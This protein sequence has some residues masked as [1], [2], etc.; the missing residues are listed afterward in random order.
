MRVIVKG[1]YKQNDKGI[2][3]NRPTAFIYNKLFSPTALGYDRYKLVVQVVIGELRGQGVKWVSW[4]IICS[5]I[6]HNSANHVCSTHGLCAQSGS[7]CQFILMF[8]CCLYHEP[9]SNLTNLTNNLWK[10]NATEKAIKRET[11]KLSACFL[12]LTRMTSKC[13]WDA[14]TDNYAEEVFINVCLTNYLL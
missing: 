4:A 12:C 2:T 3:C 14:D 8:N 9:W 6:W 5:S 13:F 10:E 11:D 1:V 7:P